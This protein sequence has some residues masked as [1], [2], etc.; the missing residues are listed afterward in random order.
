M[1]SSSR[2]EPPIPLIIRQMTGDGSAY[3]AGYP[4]LVF[5]YLSDNAHQNIFTRTQTLHYNFRLR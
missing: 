2:G 5:E 3:R 4:V 1:C